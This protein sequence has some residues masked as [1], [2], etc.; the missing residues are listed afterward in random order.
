MFAIIKVV[1]NINSMSD[2]EVEVKETSPKTIKC[3]LCH[4]QLPMVMGRN[5]AILREHLKVCPGPPPVNQPNT[6]SPT[7]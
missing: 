3:S 2:K 7:K 1:K 5:E 6:P 4:Q